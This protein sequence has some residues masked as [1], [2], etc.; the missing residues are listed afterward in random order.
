MLP[1]RLLSDEAP[2]DS[3]AAETEAPRISRRTAFAGVAL[4]S[5]YLLSPPV[6]FTV[7]LIARYEALDGL[8]LWSVAL[9]LAWVVTLHLWVPQTFWLHVGLA[10]LYVATAVDLFVVRNLGA[11]LG[12]SYLAILFTDYGEAGEFLTAYGR[13]VCGA[14][15]LLVAVYAVGLRA[16]RA[17]RIVAPR[18]ARWTALALLLA[19]YAAP[20]ARQAREVPLRDALLDVA[21]HDFSSPAGV[22]LQSA[23]TL[24]HLRRT[25]QFVGERR[26]FSF[27]A[28]RHSEAADEEETYVFVIGE[29]A[30]ADHWSLDGYARDTNPLLRGE[31][32]LVFL[33]DVLATAPHT[34]VA[35][36]SM[37][38]LADVTDW[39]AVVAQRSL[40]S[41]FREVGFDTRWTSTQAVDSFA[42]I[43]HQIALEAG[44]I[45]YFNR[46]LDDVLVEE[47]RTAVADPRR[48]RKLLLILHTRGNHFG[49]TKYPPRFRRYPEE[50]ASRRESAINAYDNGLLFTDALLADIID[51]LR[52]RG[53]RAALVYA[54]DHGENL[55]DEDGLYG[56][57][58]G[59][60]YD[61][62]PAT[63]FWLSDR[64]A[65][66]QP[67]KVAAARA[68]ATAR[69]SQSNLTHSI[70]DLAGIE[71]RGLD[72]SKSIFS[73][74]FR[75]RPR[76]S[77]VRGRLREYTERAM[78]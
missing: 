22:L 78:P 4:L 7:E 51:A 58:I 16:I 36:P 70:L 65:A 53:T 28:T 30:R 37:L 48:A 71:A 34:A 59:N 3:H 76:W 5:A 39:H 19:G 33:P 2:D 63:L 13:P 24:A 17:L 47:L 73:D 35:V 32:N 8:L 18:W 29:S 44:T 61:L 64:L 38:S 45:H 49:T 25:E 77:L 20:V 11:R 9:S 26:A 21:A 54:S 15:A 27:G 40:V 1:A 42:G 41:A 46:R 75:E 43:T 62:R 31:S 67:A 14:A 12:S 10:P 55:G 60:E 68:H 23:A 72:L 69:L 6:I 74:R 57:A 66:A 52:A 50:A 56:H